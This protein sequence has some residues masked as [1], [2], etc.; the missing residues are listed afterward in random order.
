MQQKDISWENFELYNPDK[1]HSFENL[2]RLLFKHELCPDG[3]ILVS[4]PNH[5]GV[6]VQPVL[7]KDGK[8]ISYQSKYFTGNVQYPQIK[9]SAEATVKKY[10]N[11]LDIW[12][13]YTNRSL[14]D[15]DSYNEIVKILKE[16]GTEIKVV[17]NDEILTTILKYQYIM[18]VFFGVKNL[19]FSWFKNQVKSA[20]DDLGIRYNAAFNVET[21]ALDNLNLFLANEDGIEYI[22]SK[23]AVVLKSIEQHCDE[24]GYDE[25]ANYDYIETVYDLV[26]NLE[27][28]DITNYQ[29]A[30]FW[31]NNVSEKVNETYD[32]DSQIKAL[33]EEN[34]NGDSEKYRRELEW[35]KNITEDLVF[36]DEEINLIKNRFTIV[37]G[38]AG[39]GKSQ[40]LAMQALNNVNNG[41]ETILLLGE[42]FT[43]NSSV[44][45]QI[46]GKLALNYD[47]KKL[48]S[49]ME[50]YGQIKNRPI[51]LFID[52]INE[53]ECHKI[54]KNGVSALYDLVKEYSFVRVVISYRSGYE[55]ALFSDGM[56]NKMKSGEIATIIHKGFRGRLTE[57]TKVFFNYYGVR[58]SPVYIMQER[59]QNPLFL[60]IFCKTYKE[61][62][63]CLSFP[64]VFKQ[65][66]K[67]A[68]DEVKEIMEINLEGDLVFDFLKRIVGK[69]IDLKKRY[70]DKKTILGLDFWGEYGIVDKM[71][72]IFAVVKSGALNDFPDNG[73]MFYDLGYDLLRDY[74]Y[75]LEIQARNPAS[76]LLY[77]YIENDLFCVEDG[78]IHN[79]GGISIYI[80]LL[81]MLDEEEN[82]KLLGIIDALRDD[83]DK[84]KLIDE[85]ISSFSWRDNSRVSEN[86][87]Y[88]LV[89]KYSIRV[90]TFIDM[91]L[92]NSLRLDSKLNAYYMHEMFKKMKLNNRDSEW[93]IYINGLFD[94][95]NRL[96]QL[97]DLLEHD[98]EACKDLVD[99]ESELV[100]LLF[101]WILS[102][103]NRNLRDHSSKVI[104][105]ILYTFPDKISWFVEKFAHVNDYYIVERVFCICLGVMSKIIDIKINKEVALAVY[106]SVFEDKEV[107]QDVKVREFAY[108]TIVKCLNIVGNI[109]GIDYYMIQPPY[110]AE[111]IPIMEKQ[112]YESDD[113]GSGFNR[114]VSSMYP[115]KIP[116]RGHMYGNFGRYI[117]E[118]SLDC[119]ENVN[120]ENCYHY[121]MQY[122]KDELGYEDKY[123]SDYDG[124]GFHLNYYPGQSIN[125]ERIG[126]KYQWIALSNTI[127]RISDN[128]Y[129]RKYDSDMKYDKFDGLWELFHLR[130]FDPTIF[131]YN[132]TDIDLPQFDNVEIDYSCGDD[133]D[134][135]AEL[136]A[137]NK[138]DFF[139]ACI[140]ALTVKDKNGCTWVRLYTSESLSN[141][142]KSL[143]RK[144]YS[145]E[146]G[147][148][149]SWFQSEAFFAKNADR[150]KLFANIKH[151]NYW[152]QWFPRENSEC[153]IMLGEYPWSP[154]IKD[155]RLN[156]WKRA[157]PVAEITNSYE[158]SK[159]DVMN[160]TIYS[161][162]GCEYD[163]SI[164]GKYS[165]LLP[166]IK[167]FDYFNLIEDKKNGCFFTSDGDLVA[168]NNSLFDNGQGFLI[169]ADKL[170]KFLEDNDF[171]L[172]WILLGE[173]TFDCGE[174]TDRHIW[175]EWSGYA[176][177][178]EGTVDSDLYDMTP[179]RYKY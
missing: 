105:N 39:I 20:I 131:G 163:A 5:A 97:I 132:S 148:L 16:N 111:D 56:S 15:C 42:Y 147:D 118:S 31:Y 89:G 95:S 117:F 93:T 9:K 25:H 79:Y 121:A 41:Y 100:L 53:C 64:K 72:F 84:D 155:M 29:K 123:F 109:E 55:R 40:L 2:C 137:K 174:G 149:Y 94:E 170:Q 10:K 75:A 130:D 71:K 103:S 85:Y 104:Y 176:T 99:N 172:F 3:T 4:E 66:I 177:F 113:Y 129:I 70:L 21:E 178:E 35:E 8:I 60:S 167:L 22:N 175:R 63:R 92:E 54:W 119:F 67:H 28:V 142:K 107:L 33:Q 62:N 23:K 69:S 135:G 136:W 156:E 34:I 143:R 169:K 76:D 43:G 168:I 51:A 36:T 160:A 49:I 154:A 158:L 82:K 173:H 18:E 161:S 122:I 102:A 7:S 19:P 80:S 14:S 78:S 81:A 164:E 110:N 88:D 112:N 12:Y 165:E 59:M 38:K 17:S 46:M 98:L 24:L 83:Y 44:V 140:N 87:I 106:S 27:D 151:T 52:A 152:G 126:K 86:Y 171:C 138:G 133:S 30:L 45:D 125:I 134:K 77:K 57:A 127:A 73:E 96:Y 120:I 162:W 146:R 114:I 50:V 153:E 26:S 116:K 1:R 157:Y 6:E 141:K 13:L 144:R 61:S 179:M 145:S 11:S 91:I 139:E 124:R 108:L 128:H 166:C 68:N 58:F 47:I 65:F 150:E 48:F 101:G 115:N 32:I 90:D 37:S 159:I 74:M